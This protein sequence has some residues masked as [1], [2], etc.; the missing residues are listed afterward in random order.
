M[1]KKAAAL[2]AVVFVAVVAASLY[3]G[4]ITITIGKPKPKTFEEWVWQRAQ[5][6]A[7]A[8]NTT[9]PR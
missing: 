7:A 2:I 3:T 1:L 8:N 9:F 5:E 4:D 6:N